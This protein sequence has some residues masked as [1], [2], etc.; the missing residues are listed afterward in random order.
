MPGAASLD[1]PHPTEASRRAHGLHPVP[2]LGHFLLGAW[3]LTRLGWNG[4]PGRTM[5][6]RGVA[7]CS[8][9]AG[10]LLFEERGVMAIGS[11]SGEAVRRCVFRLRGAGV[12]EISFEDGTPF[13]LL[14]LREG[15]ARVWH[16]C[17]PDRYEGRYR[18]L[19]PDRWTL[20]WRVTG[21]RKRQLIASRFVRV[22]GTQ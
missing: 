11:Y 4:V 20:V 18:V 22:S 16:D 8:A 2:D 6:L 5:R 17:A 15:A 14:D 1:P 13:H 21:P 7:R 12:A 3:R 19:G 10:G 9:S